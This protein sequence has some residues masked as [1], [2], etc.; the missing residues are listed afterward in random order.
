MRTFTTR[1]PQHR[2]GARGTSR[3]R[4]RL[5]GERS[6]AQDLTIEE[7]SVTQHGGP[8]RLRASQVSRSAADAGSAGVGSLGLR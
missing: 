1:A 4:H 8:V 2:P 7:V 6:R 3:G 5:R